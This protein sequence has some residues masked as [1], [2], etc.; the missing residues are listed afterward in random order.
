[1]SSKWTLN[2]WKTKRST[3]LW[4]KVCGFKFLIG[5]GCLFLRHFSG[6]NAAYSIQSIILIYLFIFCN[7]EILDEGDSDSEADQDAG[8][9][10]EED[11]EEREE[12]EED[13]DGKSSV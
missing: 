10:E 13:E 2:L 1:M 6:L 9:S 8:S 4:K 3:K 7:V 12:E 5:H 11:E